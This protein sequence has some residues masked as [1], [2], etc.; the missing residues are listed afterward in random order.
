MLPTILQ[1]TTELL[2]TVQSLDV[3]P[4]CFLVTDGVCSLCTNISVEDAIIA[5]DSICRN[6]KL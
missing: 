6:F 4:D 2:N 5:I 3:P 1:D